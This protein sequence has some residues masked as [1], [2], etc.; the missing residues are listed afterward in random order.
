MDTTWVFGQQTLSELGISETD[1]KYIFNFACNIGGVLLALFGV[2]IVLQKT[3]EYTVFS[4]IL[5]VCA[6]VF[7]FLIGIF[8]MNIGNGNLH[9][10]VAMTFGI[11]M[12]IAILSMAIGDLKDGKIV[13]SGISIIVL[14]C[15]MSFIIAFNL[16]MWEPLAIF[17]MFIWVIVQTAKAKV[18]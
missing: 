3:N 17:T 2:G 4:G 12:I 9:N 7:L 15:I 11:L 1:A 16:P 10:F 13:F 8:T 14:M 18:N 6:G 5:V